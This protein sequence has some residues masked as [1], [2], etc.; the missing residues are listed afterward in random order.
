MRWPVNNA[1]EVSKCEM[2][3]VEDVNVARN[4]IN[5]NFYDFILNLRSIQKGLLFIQRS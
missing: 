4:E 5:E 3:I 1:L 2:Y